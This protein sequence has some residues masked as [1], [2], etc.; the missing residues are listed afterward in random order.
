M[1]VLE[2][3]HAVLT[4]YEVLKIVKARQDASRPYKDVRDRDHLA[5]HHRVQQARQNLLATL[6][7]HSPEGT[8]EDG[9]D[10]IGDAIS[11]FYADVSSAFPAISPPHIRNLVAI[12]PRS[13][14]ILGCLFPTPEQWGLVASHTDYFVEAIERYFPLDPDE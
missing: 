8:K 10:S 14:I 3:G 6:L 9:P 5:D 12:R 2:T 4:A 7:R 11:R 13:L 1:E